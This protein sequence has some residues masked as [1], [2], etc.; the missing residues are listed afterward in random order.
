MAEA[1]ARKTMDNWSTNSVCN[2]GNENVDS[3]SIVNLGSKG[4]ELAATLTHSV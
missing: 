3:T 2:L 1:N 4:C